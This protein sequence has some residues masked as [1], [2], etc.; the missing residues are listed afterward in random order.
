MSD[1]TLPLKNRGKLIGMICNEIHDG[2][3]ALDNIPA[4]LVKLYESGYWREFEIYNGTIVRHERFIDLITGDLPNGFRTPLAFIDKLMRGTKHEPKWQAI[5][6]E[7]LEPAAGN[8]EIGRG[9]RSG[10]TRAMVEHNNTEG[11]LRRLK[12][13]GHTEQLAAIT[14]GE[15]SVNQAAI[16]AGYRKRRASIPLDNVKAAIDVVVKHFGNAEVLADVMRR[17][18]T[19]S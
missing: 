13:D 12:R 7:E 16:S 4:S 3:E 10:N 19:D 8:G 6:A 1:P 9:D 11:I 15:M 14:A 2:G 18:G 5:K 17:M